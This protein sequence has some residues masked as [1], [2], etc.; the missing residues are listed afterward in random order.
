M[1]YKIKTYLCLRS[2]PV[3]IRS[4]NDCLIQTVV[5]GMGMHSKGRCIHSQTLSLVSGYC[6]SKFPVSHKFHPFRFVS[7]VRRR[8]NRC[9]RQVLGGALRLVWVTLGPRKITRFYLSAWMS[10]GDMKAQGKPTLSYP[11]NFDK[12]DHLIQ[13]PSA[14]WLFPANRKK[15]E[16]TRFPLSFVSVTLKT[17]WPSGVNQRV[18]VYYSGPSLWA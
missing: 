12:G 14:Q 16:A 13:I 8:I 17:D 15:A 9:H 2:S 1:K 6:P 3:G 7:H 5:Y 18:V 11:S 4:C 10:G